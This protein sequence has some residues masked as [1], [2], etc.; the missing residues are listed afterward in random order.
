MGVNVKRLGG[1][2]TNRDFKKF[3][4]NKPVDYAF[5]MNEG[6]PGAFEVTRVKNAELLDTRVDGN[7]VIVTFKQ[8]KGR[9]NFDVARTGDEEL[10]GVFSQVTARTART[11]ASSTSARW[12]AAS[13]RAT[14]FNLIRE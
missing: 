3:I 14:R 9:F 12:R 4:K 1:K 6:D 13:M 7:M 8:K 5:R 10:V 2:P 11:P